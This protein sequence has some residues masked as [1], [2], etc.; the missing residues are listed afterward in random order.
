M[1]TYP[2][3]AEQLARTSAFPPKSLTAANCFACEPGEGDGLNLNRGSAG[4]RSGVIGIAADLAGHA[5]CARAREHGF[6]AD[7]PHERVRRIVHAAPSQGVADGLGVE[8]G[9]K[10]PRAGRIQYD[11][12]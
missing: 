10:W 9:H 2:P 12:P 4:P 5:K 6:V 1:Q 3:Y 7:L 8:C 11:R